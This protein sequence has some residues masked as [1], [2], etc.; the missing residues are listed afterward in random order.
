MRRRPQRAVGLACAR[1]VPGQGPLFGS[2]HRY[3]NRFWIPTSSA[4]A[5]RG[6]AV[7]EVILVGYPVGFA[8]LR[9]AVN[10]GDH[11]TIGKVTYG[12]RLR[13][14]LAPKERIRD[15][16]VFNNPRTVVRVEL[17]QADTEIG[18]A[19]RGG[20]VK[21]IGYCHPVKD[22]AAYPSNAREVRIASIGEL[23]LAA[24]P[25]LTHQE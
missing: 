6:R 23:R 1:D 4:V 9:L 13:I 18:L 7:R 21:L 20:G 16:E 19:V 11:E 10:R 5:R 25:P 24:T 3:L 22:V 15:I 14:H 17:T 2:H 8:E 12:A